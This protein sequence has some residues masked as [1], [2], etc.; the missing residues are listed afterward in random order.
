MAMTDG[1]L[2]SGYGNGKFGPNDPITVVELEVILTR[3]TGLNID[4]D[5]G[6]YNEL[7]TWEW[8]SKTYGYNWTSEPWF[9]NYYIACG[10]MNYTNGVYAASGEQGWYHQLTRFEAITML[11]NVFAMSDQTLEKALYAKNVAATGK[12]RWTLD[13]LG[14]KADI[15]AFAEANYISTRSDYSYKVYDPILFAYDTGLVSGIDSK[16]SFGLNNGIT[17]AELCQILHNSGLIHAGNFTGA[18]TYVYMA[19]YGEYG[20]EERF[21]KLHPTYHAPGTSWNGNTKT[22]IWN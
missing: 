12:T 9:W 16:H 2:V 10:R 7:S 8:H 20:T 1:G 17:R 21:Y 13:D 14:D 3:L 4:H 11:Y 15:V 22:P 6:A 19:R 5:W 18:D